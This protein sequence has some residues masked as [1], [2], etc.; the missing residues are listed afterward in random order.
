MTVTNPLLID[1]LTIHCGFHI[2]FPR[3]YFM[4]PMCLC[5]LYLQW[6]RESCILNVFSKILCNCAS[7]M[8]W[9]SK[10]G[11]VWFLSASAIISPPGWRLDTIVTICGVQQHLHPGRKWRLNFVAS[12]QIIPSPKH[13]GGHCWSTTELVCVVGLKAPT[14][15]L[16]WSPHTMN[17]T[18]ILLSTDVDL[19]PQISSK[20]RGFTTF[21][22]YLVASTSKCWP[23][24]SIISGFHWFSLT[25]QWWSSCL[26]GQITVLTSPGLNPWVTN[27]LTHTSRPSLN[28][29]RNHLIIAQGRPTIWIIWPEPS[30]LFGFKGDQ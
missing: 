26:P 13:I 22:S 30:N 12:W 10:R 16:L 28:S 19:E 5:G 23:C 29:P 25:S 9:W 8:N 18:L 3:D 17:I 7:E 20:C 6:S 11:I 24:D 4:M 15:T 2:V 21:P 27:G 1:L 14:T